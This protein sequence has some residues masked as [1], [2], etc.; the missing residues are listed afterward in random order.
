M[1]PILVTLLLLATT[2]A[3]ADQN[4]APTARLKITADS[5]A[6]A[7]LRSVPAE[8]ATERF[9][10]STADLGTISYVGLATGPVG[11]V[12]FRDGSLLGTLTRRQA[13]AFY[14]CRGYATARY[15]YWAQEAGQ[16]AAS[17]ARHAQPALEI[18]LGFSG[19]STS[20]SIKAILDNPAMGQMQA[21]VEMGTNPL[22][23][24]R[25]LSKVHREQR[26]READE[27]MARALG[28]LALGDSEKRLADVAPPQDVAFTERGLVLAYP[29]Y[30]VDFLVSNGRIEALQQPSFLQLARAKPALFYAPD[31]AWSNCTPELWSEALPGPEAASGG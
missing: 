28:Q 23:V 7:V 9:E 11:G 27:N 31:M 26:Q 24:V 1:R 3:L 12:V 29:K 18:E 17:L 2:S 15:Q 22:K 20:H 30:S 4:A 5:D 13:E 19:A 10:V 16:W 21:L 14:A 6:R 8:A 25:A